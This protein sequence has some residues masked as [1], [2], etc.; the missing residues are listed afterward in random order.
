MKV[1]KFRIRIVVAK[2]DKEIFDRFGEEFIRDFKL[3]SKGKLPKSEY[4]LEITFPNV[5]DLA[6]IFSPER[7]RLIQAIKDARP[8]SIYQLAKMLRRE[9]TNVHKDVQELASLGVIEL[10]KVKKKGQKRESIHPEY[11]W[12]GFDI[13]V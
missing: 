11:N 13:A 9:S 1:R 10:K 8:E 12:D 6:R 5:A 2:S 4:E 7:I 3:A